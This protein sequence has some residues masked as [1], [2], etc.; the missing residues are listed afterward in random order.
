M[1]LG[2]DIPNFGPIMLHPLYSYYPTYLL[3][4][5][6][7][8]TVMS[9]LIGYQLA[10]HLGLRWCDGAI[11]HTAWSTTT[12]QS[13][14]TS[15]SGLNGGKNAKK[16]PSTYG[17]VYVIPESCTSRFQLPIPISSF[18]IPNPLQKLVYAR[19]ISLHVR[20]HTVNIFCNRVFALEL[21]S[22]GDWLL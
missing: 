13:T 6:I 22:T 9:Q 17:Q 3:D 11:V 16:P 4:H 12:A 10:W 7:L 5:I 19:K 20:I 1:N 2:N 8:F 14:S 21:V 18:L 15:P